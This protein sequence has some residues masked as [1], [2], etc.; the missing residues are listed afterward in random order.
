MTGCLIIGATSAVAGAV[1]ERLAERGARLYCLARN[2]DK[3]TR[4][5]GA[6]GDALVG[7]ECFDFNATDQAAD[8]IERARTD[9][10]RID[11]TLIAH[12]MLPDQVATEHDYELARTTFETNLLSVVA[13]LI[14]LVDIL[15]EQGGGKLGVITSVAGDRG[16]PRNYT[17]GAAKGALAIYLQGLRSRLWRDGVEVYTFKLGPVDSPMTV[18]HAKNPSFSSVSRVADGIVR[19]YDGGRY[20]V[21]IPGWWA[22]VMLAVRSMPEWLFQRLSFLSE[23]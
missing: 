5:E 19:A 23:R 11:L 20:V 15:L 3:M 6:L 10:G 14:P 12:G 4:L 7:Y 17:Y 2:T 16:R 22:A 8:A 1:A 21:Y 13:L 18:D 9:L